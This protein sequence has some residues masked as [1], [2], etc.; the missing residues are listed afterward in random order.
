MVRDKYA[1]SDLRSVEAYGRK[2]YLRAR[3]YPDALRDYSE[4]YSKARTS[5]VEARRRGAACPPS[6]VLFVPVGTYLGV[7]LRCFGNDATVPAFY[8]YYCAVLRCYDSVLESLFKGTLSFRRSCRNGFGACVRS[9][10]GFAF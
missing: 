8:I 9:G 1:V 2:Y 10:F 3:L 6:K 5:G 4:T 7:V